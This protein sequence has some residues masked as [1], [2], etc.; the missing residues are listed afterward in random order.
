MPDAKISDTALEVLRK[1]LVPG[2]RLI[3][4]AHPSGLAL[5]KRRALWSLFGAVIAIANFYLAFGRRGGAASVVAVF[6]DWPFVV[7]GT[8]LVFWPIWEFLR[9][10][11]TTYAISDRRLLISKHGL[12]RIIKSYTASEIQEIDRDDLGGGTGDVNFR[13]DIYRLSDGKRHKSQI[14][15]FGVREAEHVEKLIRDL[16]DTRKKTTFGTPL[17][18]NIDRAASSEHSENGP[19]RVVPFDHSDTAALSSLRAEMVPE[20]HLVW[21]GQPKPVVLAL[22]GLPFALIGAGLFGFGLFHAAPAFFGSQNVFNGIF[23]AGT[24]VGLL[25][26]VAWP[27]WLFIDAGWTIYA[28]SDRHILII[29]DCWLYDCNSYTPTPARLQKIVSRVHSDGT[30]NVVFRVEHRV[31]GDRDVEIGFFGI[32]D[33]RRVAELVSELSQNTNIVRAA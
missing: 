10:K 2:E 17:T 31:L 18:A 27:C 20:E 5:A 12:S 26:S 32:A 1:E 19:P 25:C 3:W 22:R 16:A 23:A 4:A 30:G 7:A 11:T 29:K 9:A 8:V 6:F 15:L 33:V 21:V 24:L 14:G 28:I 13:S